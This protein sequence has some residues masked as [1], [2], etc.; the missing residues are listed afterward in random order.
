MTLRNV[1]RVAEKFTRKSESF[2]LEKASSITR[3]AF[4]VT[5]AEKNWTEQTRIQAR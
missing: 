4:F 2:R 3:N 5:F 1:L